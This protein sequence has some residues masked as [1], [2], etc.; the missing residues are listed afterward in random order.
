MGD[1]LDRWG[2]GVC[3]HDGS[4][5]YVNMD[6]YKGSTHD[7]PMTGPSILSSERTLHLRYQ[8]VNLFRSHC[9]SSIFRTFRG[10]P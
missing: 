6:G 7:G 10:C 8:S 4:D 9:V 1:R 2:S 5:D 3:P